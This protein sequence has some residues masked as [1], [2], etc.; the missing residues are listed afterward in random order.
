MTATHVLVVDDNDDLREILVMILGENQFLTSQASD[1]RQ[2]IDAARASNP[3]VILMDI[4]MPVMDG[5]RATSALKSDSTLA[6]IPVIAQTAHPASIGDGEANFFAV[7]TKPCD[8]D[9]V[10]ATL[11]RASELTAGAHSAAGD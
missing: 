11:R 4:H 9:M 1:G 8:P 3:D 2:A 7:L 5:L 6:H 10:I